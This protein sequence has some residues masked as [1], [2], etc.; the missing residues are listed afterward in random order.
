MDLAQQKKYRVVCR[1]RQMER[2]KNVRL[3]DRGAGLQ[4]KET[5]VR[6]AQKSNGGLCGD[7]C[8]NGN[9]HFPGVYASGLSP[10]IALFCI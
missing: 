4:K 1:I 8:V 5:Y 3:Q 7:F 2:G 6:S 10:G 9:H